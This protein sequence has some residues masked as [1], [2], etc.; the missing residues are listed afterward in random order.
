MLQDVIATTA[1]SATKAYAVYS[2]ATIRPALYSVYPHYTEDRI[3]AGVSVRVI[4][5]GAGGEMRGLDERKWLTKDESAP[6]YTLI[7]PGKIAMV[8]VAADGTP[9]A[10][11]ITDRNLAETEQLIFDKLWKRL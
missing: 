6:T 5:L 1:A 7:Y 3:A 9:R 11:V 10:V 4:A 2:S 8:T